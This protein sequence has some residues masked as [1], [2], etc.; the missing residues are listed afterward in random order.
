M[1]SLVFANDVEKGVT[2]LLRIFA[3]DIEERGVENISQAE[4]L[5]VYV[6]IRDKGRK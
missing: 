5:D 2:S 1:S 4:K 6:L 3:N